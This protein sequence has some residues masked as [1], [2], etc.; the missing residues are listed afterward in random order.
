MLELIKFGTNIAGHVVPA[1]ANLRVVES[2]TAKI[3]YSLEC[4][5]KQL[6]KT[7]ALSPGDFI[8]TEPR[9]AMTQRDLNNYLS[10]VEG[11]EGVELRQLGSFLKTSEEEGL[12]GNLYRMTTPSG[13]VKWVCKDHYRASY[14]EKHIQALREVVELAQ[15][16][17]D[18]QMGRITITL[19]STIAA[20]VF[21][22]AV[23]KAKSIFELFLSLDWKCTSNDLEKLEVALKNSSV[24]IL[25]LDLRQFPSGFR[26]R[27]SSVQHALFRIMEQFNMKIIHIVIPKAFINLLTPSLKRP[28]HL[29]ELSFEMVPRSIGRMELK[30]LSETL[31]TNSFLTTLNLFNNCIGSNGGQAL[32][33]I[34]DANSALTTLNLR[35]NWIGNSGGQWVWH[36]R[37][38]RR[39]GNC[40]L[41]DIQELSLGPP[42]S[43]VIPL[44]KLKEMYAGLMS[45]QFSTAYLKVAIESSG[46]VGCDETFLHW[47]QSSEPSS[48]V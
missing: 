33:E 17:F 31:K 43:C 35:G 30:I 19:T 1:L 15:G 46:N 47:R 3:D 32:A 8:G 37:L 34:L 38:L 22:K 5:D 9:V 21:Y 48:L 2:V 26:D 6:A 29:C 40:W 44:D 10:D 36:Q 27:F 4:I 45:L 39:F 13:H 28:S 24:S 7:Q 42:S 16:K 18:E 14:Q 41:R 25:W 23:S 20:S 11:L 12:L